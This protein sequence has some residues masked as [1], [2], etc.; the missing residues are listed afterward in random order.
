MY[1]DPL[2]LNGEWSLPK[3][4]SKALKSL[5]HHVVELVFQDPESINLGEQISSLSANFDVLLCMYAGKSSQ[6]ENAISYAK[7]INSKLIVINELGDEP[8]TFKSNYSRAHLSDIILSP[9]HKSTLAWR[10]KGFNC[11]WFTHWADTE[12][13]YRDPSINKVSF[14]STTIGKRRY[15]LLLKMMLG[16]RFINRRIKSREN[17]IFYNQSHCAFQYARWGEVTRRIFEASACGCCVLTNRLRKETMVE[18][19]F[20]HNVHIVYYK[21]PFS[22]V[23]EILVL[24]CDPSKQTRIGLNALKLVLEGHTSIQRARQLVSLIDSYFS[25][26]LI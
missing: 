15:S 25:S 7:S 26:H 11:Y 4:F 1:H 17:T 22:L 9:C 10:E 20:K 6:L 19:I 18:T 24:L 3:G 12:I 14:M 13:F 5:G 16:N 23:W 2:E 8:Q 21:G